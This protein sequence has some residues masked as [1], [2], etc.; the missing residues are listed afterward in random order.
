[1]GWLVVWLVV[2]MA[3]ALVLAQR[4]LAVQREAFEVDA[5]IAH[6]LLSQRAV[7]HEAVLAT[8]VLL[9]PQGAGGAEQRLPSVHPRILTVLRRDSGTD[10]A[11]PPL[12]AAESES[13]R[14]GHAASEVGQFARGR[15]WVVQAGEAASHALE[16]DVAA[17]MQQADWPILPGGAVAVSLQWAGQTAVLEAGRPDAGVWRFDFRKPLAAASQPFDVT[18]ER[19]LGWGAL[20]WGGML[21]WV[22]ASAAGVGAVAALRRQ[23]AARGRAEELLRLGQVSR[24]NALGELAAGMAHEL[25]QP[26]TAVL[27]GTQAA[28]RVL[29]EDP[30]DVEIAREAVT[31][32]AEQARRAA[33]VV[34]RLRRAVERPE[35]GGQARPVA[36]GEAVRN[37]LYLIEPECARHGVVPRLEGDELRVL[38]EPVA[39]EQIIHNL[40]TNALQALSRVAVG[41]RT[42]VLQIAQVGG[43]GV[44]R[45]CDTG[46]GIAE[47]DRPRIFEPFFTTREGGLGLGLSLCETLATAMGGSLRAEPASGRGTVFRLALPLG[48]KL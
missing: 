39:L 42:L 7:E 41:E 24:L 6:R 38:A 3:G 44:L 33:D 2:A 25:N 15:Y 29:D 4:Q 30:P 34:G 13:R 26:L 36:L 31:H 47:A 22:L 8:L 45:V 9:A 16:I 17:M 18:L 5:R 27:A 12:S 20:P 11:Y 35:L 28:R 14:S 32:A 40:L 43:E 1:M 19:S 10:W 48:E 46:S 37:A 21:A 23:M